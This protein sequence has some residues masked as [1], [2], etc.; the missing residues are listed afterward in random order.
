MTT[1][2]AGGIDC[3]VHIAVP[4]MKALL[5]YLEDHWREIIVLRG[6]DGLDLTSYP[7]GAPISC[8]EDWRAPGR[9]PGTD[10]ERL[11]RHALDGFGSRHA[12]A[13][14]LYG[15][16]AVHSEDL[17]AAL[18]RALN[19][20]VAAEWLSPEPR[21]RASIVVPWQ[22]PELAA[23]EIERCAP[24]QRFVQVQLLVMGDTPLGKRSNWPIYRA[25]AAHGLPVAVHAGSA[26]RHAPSAATGWGSY[27][28]EDYAANAT[29]F[30]GQVLSLLHEGVLSTFPELRFVLAESGVT[31]LP[32]LLWRATKTWR[33]LRSE[34][35]WVERS[36][37]ELV[38][39][40]VRFTLQP[41]DAPPG[42]G[43]ELE[44]F[45]EHLGSDDLLLFST[46]YPHWHFDGD[47]V[48][49]EGLPDS[50]ARKA[51]VD[52]PLAT[53]PRLREDVMAG[54][55]PGAGRSTTEASEGVTS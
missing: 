9:R 30:Q 18:C 5:P 33:A 4:A 21:L 40:Q 43:A 7:P 12:I 22:S 34:V 48:W 8:R 51:L 25:A 52:N 6:M 27:L 54:P 14:V 41:F 53:Y 23:A 15:A 1:S 13:H 3:D 11:R 49:P 35:P 42:G 39:D 17:A 19:D 45:L 50:W 24:D 28:V 37:E 32:T 26:Y 31:W 47:G 46:D 20:W 29:A 44:R 55:A 10:L 36:P 2:T 38:R 16:Q